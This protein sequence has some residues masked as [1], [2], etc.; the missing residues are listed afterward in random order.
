MEIEKLRLYTYFRSSA[1]YRVRI[2]LH[3][4]NIA[5]SSNPINLAQQAQQSSEYL[6]LNPAGLVPMLV[7]NDQ[8]MTQS[9]AIIEYLNEVYPDPPL[10]PNDPIARA[11]VRAMALLIACDI[12]PLNNLRVLQ[13]LSQTIKI[14]EDQKQAWYAHWINQG[15]HALEKIVANNQSSGKYCYG[16]NITVA[17]ICLIPQ[18]YN[19]QRFSVSLEKFPHIQK[20]NDHCLLLD[21]F[22][23]AHPDKQPD[24]K[25][26]I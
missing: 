15:F 4:K 12:H 10:Y 19:A 25:K 26:S 3:I 22:K 2:A 11:E 18:V 14:S 13:Y 17:D 7:D 20:I 16:N 21:C 8:A 23:D 9:L 6:S 24:A 5:Y 1:A